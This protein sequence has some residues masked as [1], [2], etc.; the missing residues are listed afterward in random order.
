MDFTSTTPVSAP[1]TDA[2]DVTAVAAVSAYAAPPVWVLGIGYAPVGIGGAVTLMALPQLLAAQ[3]VPEPIIASLTA[4]A[5]APGFVAFIFGPLL[6]WRFRRKSYAIAFTLMGGVGLFAALMSTGNL[7]AVAFWEFFSMLAISIG[8]CAVGG[9]FS[10]LIPKENA[11]KLGAWFTAWNIGSGG[12]TAMFAVNLIRATSFPFGA[13][14]L[15]ALGA[16]AVLLFILLPCRAAD[17][18]LAHESVKAFASDVASTLRSRSI[19]WSL[20]LFL[21]PTASF[22]LTNVIAGLGRDFSTSEHTVGLMVG[23]GAMIAGIFG[24]LA[25]PKVERWI[26]PRTLYL[27]IGLVGA[28]ATM[29][30]LLLPRDPFAFAVA[31]LS[32]NVCQSAGFAVVYAITLRTIGQDNPLAATQFS[33]LSSAMCL[34]LTY[35]QVLDGEGYALGHVQGA[36]LMDAGV[37]GAASVLLMAVFWK[38]RSIIPRD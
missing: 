13:V 10:D 37:S 33:L 31:V 3:R 11:G 9:W 35:M 19:L 24:S 26:S 34:P 20:L 32:E 14:V 28:L 4:F 38:F 21:S 12:I 30:I 16:S 5:L 27:V 2:P 18:R 36:F 1:S 8:S 25:M 29:L 7:T 15:G 6:D 23:V 17:G 22:A